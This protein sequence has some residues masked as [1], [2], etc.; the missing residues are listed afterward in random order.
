[1]MWG[2]QSNGLAGGGT[3]RSVDRSSLTTMDLVTKLFPRSF[4]RGPIEAGLSASIQAR[5]QAHFRDHLI[6]APL[7]LFRETF[8]NGS[9]GAISAII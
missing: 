4:D 5:R 9:F 7:K 2:E 8:V 1:M 6:A 3:A